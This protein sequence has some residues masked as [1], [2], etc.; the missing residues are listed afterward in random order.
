MMTLYQKMKRTMVKSITLIKFMAKSLTMKIALKMILK[1]LK[2]SMS[3]SA[4]NLYPF[5]S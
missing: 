4:I 2:I 1:R 3:R 5:L